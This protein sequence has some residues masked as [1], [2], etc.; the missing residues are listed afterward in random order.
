MSYDYDGGDIYKS[1][2]M[3][4]MDECASEVHQDGM[5]EHGSGW[6]LEWRSLGIL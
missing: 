4:S 6:W 3:V 5:D 1:D 2:D